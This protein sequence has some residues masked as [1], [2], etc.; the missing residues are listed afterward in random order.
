MPT[1]A[2]FFIRSAHFLYFE[3][4]NG[5]SPWPGEGINTHFATH[6]SYRT[7]AKHCFRLC[8]RSARSNLGLFLAPMNSGLLRL[9][10]PPPKAVAKTPFCV[11]TTLLN[12]AIRLALFYRLILERML[13]SALCKAERIEA[14]W[15]FAALSVAVREVTVNG[16]SLLR[17]DLPR[18]MVTG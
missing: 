14:I 7:Y 1:E 15:E 18:P 16:I 2:C 3:L 17:K 11:G 13:S 5:F 6:S 4:R 8:E 9:T 12:S 10:S